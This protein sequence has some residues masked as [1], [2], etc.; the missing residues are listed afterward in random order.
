MTNDPPEHDIA[1]IRQLLLAAFTPEELD[2]LFRSS[3]SPQLQN[4]A[5]EFSPGDGLTIMADKAISYSRRYLLL[6]EL[7][8]ELKQHNPRQYA[9]F[10]EPELSE[11]K[12]APP[13]PELALSVGDRDT[14]TSPIRLD[15]VR[16]PAGRFQMGS[17]MARDKHAQDAELPPHPIHVP[18][19]HIGQYPVTNRQYKAFVQATGHRAPKHWEEGWIPRGKYNHPVVYVSW[20]D[21]VAFCTWLS[22]GTGQPFRLPTEAE[23]EKAARGTDGRTYPW[24]DEPP[25]KLRCNFNK[26]AGDTT[27]IGRYSPQGDSPYGCAGMAGNVWE[28][29]Q[30]LDEPYPYQADDGREDL[31]ASGDRVLR[32]GSWFDPPAVVRCASRPSYDPDSWAVNFGFRIAREPLG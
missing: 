30:S 7:L 11:D 28:W 27:T 29:C 14:I 23:W 25:N 16:V 32:G 2:R 10:I 3:S 18:E 31:Q 5:K 4:V 13:T 17:V 19:F 12:P 9:R 1:K 15:L 22:Q 6:P 26:N 8:A 24:G 21:A 20:R